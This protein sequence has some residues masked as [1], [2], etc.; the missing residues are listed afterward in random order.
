MQA[1]ENSKGSAALALEMAALEQ[2]QTELSLRT[3]VSLVKIERLGHKRSGTSDHC[4]RTPNE[5]GLFC[6]DNPRTRSPPVQSNS[7]EATDIE[8]IEMRKNDHATL[9]SHIKPI[10]ED[11]IVD[12][13]VAEG[14]CMIERGLDCIMDA[15][16]TKHQSENAVHERNYQEATKA[17]TTHYSNKRRSVCTQLERLR[18]VIARISSQYEV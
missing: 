17:D 18:N 10:F 11:E 12:K 8:I 7:A 2:E 1:C 13:R 4:V 14:L 5:S 3:P 15:S 16:S 9:H 6:D